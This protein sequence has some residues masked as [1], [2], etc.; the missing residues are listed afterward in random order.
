MKM[1]VS[2]RL[3]VRYTF[4]SP[5][6]CSDAEHLQLFEAGVAQLEVCLDSHFLSCNALAVLL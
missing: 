4:P 6:L 1:R 2:W 3:V 5:Y